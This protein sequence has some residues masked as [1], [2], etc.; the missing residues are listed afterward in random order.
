ML[1]VILWKDKSELQ[2]ARTKLSEEMKKF[3]VKI[4]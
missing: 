3:I 1:Y 4:N 2:A